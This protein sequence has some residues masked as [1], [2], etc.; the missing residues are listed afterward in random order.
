MDIGEVPCKLGWAPWGC[1]CG[2]VGREKTAEGGWVGVIVA[3]VLALTLAL[4]LPLAFE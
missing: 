2:V 4:E 1:I 3:L